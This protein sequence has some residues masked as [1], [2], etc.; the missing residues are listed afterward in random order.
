MNL[1][2]VLLWTVVCLGA[3]AFVLFAGCSSDDSTTKPAEDGDKV[4][5]TVVGHFPASD[6]T[7]VTRI[8]PYW[9]AFSEAMNASSVEAG[10][11]LL[12]QFTYN[13]FWRGD[14]LFITPTVLL[15]GGAAHT[16]TIGAASTDLAG[17]ALG[18]DYAI[19]FTTTSAS[20][21]VAPEIVSTVPADEAVGV[22]G[23]TTI[24]I[25][26]S[27]PM[28][29]AS[30]QAALQSMP[31]LHDDWYEWETLVLKI[32]HSPFPQDSLITITVGTG[33]EDLTGNTLAAPYEFS[34]R[35][36]LDDGAP[37]LVS[38]SPANGATSVPTDLAQVILTF[39]EPMDMSTFDLPAQYVDARLNQLVREEPSFSGDYTTLT[40]P[41]ARTLLAGCTYWVQLINVMDGAGN[42]IDPNPTSYAFT[43][44]GSQSLYPVINDAAWIYIH[45]G[46]GEATRLIA[47][48]VQGGYFD[49][50]R[51]NDI[52][53]IE[54]KVHLRKTA[55]TIQHLGRSE[56]DDGEYE[57]T[58]TWNDPITYIRLPIESYLG[59]SWTFSTTGTIDDSTSM[60][61]SG[62]VEME[63]IRVDLLSAE[64][65]GTFKGCCVHHL[66]V[67]YTIYVNGS[68]V[69]SGNNHQTMWLAPGV[70]PVRII[71]NDGGSADTLNVADWDM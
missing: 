46:G 25:T 59:S 41:F 53:D 61:L 49:E 33:A 62:H 68:P 15:S 70:G 7:D 9:V 55:S 66:Y 23:L 29:Q 34:F 47:N 63:P 27:E 28:N 44:S 5:P 17:N 12:P 40:V 52:G 60:D 37:Y 4:Q 56:Y 31:P 71:N 19:A 6:A 67:D 54:E 39:S 26:F 45:D 18:A 13:L 24:E 57:F 48:Y 36:Q 65:H 20:D 42:V 16:I 51:L 43:T 3:L 8:G 14:T 10:L 2:R 1:R 30:V 64:L 50:V 21:Y 38:A 32:H 35:T 69:D 22:N 11:A 58:M